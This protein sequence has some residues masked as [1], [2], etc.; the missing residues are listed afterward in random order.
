MAFDLY[1]HARV[2]VEP[3]IAQ[4]RGGALAQYCLG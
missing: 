1:A 4:A 3:D 2:D